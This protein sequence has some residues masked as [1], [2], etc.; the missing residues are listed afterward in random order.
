VSGAQ[1]PPSHRNL[2]G[3]MMVGTVVANVHPKDPK[4]RFVR[5]RFKGL[6][7]GAKDDELPW[8][9]IGRPLFRGGGPSVGFWTMPRVG[10][11]VAGFFDNGARGSFVVTMEIDDPTTT[12]ESE[13][14]EAWDLTHWGVQDEEGTHI[15]VKVG[16]TFEIRHKEALIT[17]AADGAIS[18]YSPKGIVYEAGEGHL[19]K[20]EATFEDDVTMN[21][22]LEV[23]EEA[24]IGGIEFTPHT[25]SGV[26]TGGGNT[27]GPQ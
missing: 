4:L 20:G 23:A 15:K 11:K 25:H 16:E 19:F 27:G 2:L 9:G 17:V 26:Q 7:D 6:D 10:T 3:R 1:L 13:G 22:N 5:V 24:T 18:V 8:S 21:S 14:D 12:F